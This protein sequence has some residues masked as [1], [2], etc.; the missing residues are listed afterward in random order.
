LFIETSCVIYQ[1]SNITGKIFVYLANDC[2]TNLVFILLID[3]LSF[4]CIIMLILIKKKKIMS[5][6]Y[7]VFFPLNLSFKNYHY[8]LVHTDFVSLT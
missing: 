8:M 4:T 7:W 2:D 6:I 1:D 3:I 5:Q